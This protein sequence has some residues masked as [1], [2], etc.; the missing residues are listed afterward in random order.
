LPEM[1]RRLSFSPPY[2]LRGKRVRVRLQASFGD[3]VVDSAPF[4]L[5]IL[6]GNI[7][8][9]KYLRAALWLGL[10][11]LVLWLGYRVAS[12]Y[13]TKVCPDCARIQRHTD[14]GCLFCLQNRDAFII[15]NFNVRDKRKLGHSDLV[16]LVSDSSE[17]GTHRRSVVQLIKSTQKRRACYVT[18]IREALPK[19]RFAYRLVRNVSDS[20]VTISVNSNPI[21]KDRYLSSGD[22]LQI[23]GMEISFYSGMEDSD[24]A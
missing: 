10:V 4:N 16:R 7:F 23:D 9:E 8:L 21:R 13:R 17:I 15:G 5:N 24:V 3:K 18:I 11:L 14:P 12:H 6:E 1:R 20:S 22:V 19:N 2:D